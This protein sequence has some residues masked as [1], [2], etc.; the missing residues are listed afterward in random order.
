MLEQR[1][2][3]RESAI[4]GRLMTKDINFVTYAVHRRVAEIRESADELYA[5]YLVFIYPRTTTIN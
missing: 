4:S 3:F 2:F 1:Y 5:D